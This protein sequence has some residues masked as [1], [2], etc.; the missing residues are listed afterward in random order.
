[1]KTM[2]RLVLAAALTSAVVPSAL[3]SA[4]GG[5]NP[6]PP[7][8]NLGPVMSS[9]PGGTNPSPILRIRASIR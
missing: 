9:A 3:A 4:P 7:I 5:T 8:P 2:I 1:M 6:C